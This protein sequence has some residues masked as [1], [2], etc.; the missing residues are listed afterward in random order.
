M[1][2]RKRRKI[3]QGREEQVSNVLEEVKRVKHAYERTLKEKNEVIRDLETQLKYQEEVDL[4]MSKDLK[5]LTIENMQLYKIFKYARELVEQILYHQLEKERVYFHSGPIN[6]LDFDELCSL[7]YGHM[8]E[9]RREYELIPPVRLCTFSEDEQTY[10]CSYI[11]QFTSDREVDQVFF[12]ALPK[13]ILPPKRCGNITISVHPSRSLTDVALLRKYEPF[14]NGLQMMS[15]SGQF[16]RIPQ[17]S[18]PVSL[19]VFYIFP[20]INGKAERRIV[21]LIGDTHNSTLNMCAGTTPS[22][23]ALTLLTIFENTRGPHDLFLESRRDIRLG[24]AL[25]PLPRAVNI[26][27]RDVEEPDQHNN[28]RVHWIDHRSDRKELTQQNSLIFDD[29]DGLFEDCMKY[30]YES[31]KQYYLDHLPSLKT[32]WDLHIYD[33][34]DILYIFYFLVYFEKKPDDLSDEETKTLLRFWTPEFCMGVLKNIVKL[35]TSDD[36]YGENLDRL[37]RDPTNGIW[38]NPKK[39]RTGFCH[40]SCY[41]IRKQLRGLSET[42]R[43]LLISHFEK[44]LKLNIFDTF[45]EYEEKKNDVREIE[46]LVSK[47]RLFF[48]FLGVYLVEVYTIGR[49]FKHSNR[50]NIFYYAGALHCWF[51][52]EFLKKMEGFRKR[53]QYQSPEIIFEDKV[54]IRDV[55]RCID[56]GTKKHIIS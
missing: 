4:K 18:G 46:D 22:N 5:T 44:Q 43:N 50:K 31:V 45:E 40:T 34:N 17:I 1:E 48:L 20:V 23:F 32:R 7:M 11:I 49:M 24:N 30:P 41:R 52:G 42:N 55:N 37:L 47:Y 38:K 19:E 8:S 12:K 35:L 33:L 36:V 10:G 2:N 9:L 26:F 3:N 56:T 27:Q 15:S 25:L 16:T 28:Y 21:Y 51:T 13:S 39:Y 53:I 6:S 54:D 29:I 14:E